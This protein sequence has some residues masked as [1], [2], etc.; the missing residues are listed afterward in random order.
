MKNILFI[1]LFLIVSFNCFSEDGTSKN[2][3]KT[4]QEKIKA[5]KELEKA[6]QAEIEKV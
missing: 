6:K 1:F 4:K 3:T 5:D 2:L